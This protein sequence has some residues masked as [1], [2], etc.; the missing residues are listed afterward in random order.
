MHTSLQLTSG[1]SAL[2][3]P[4]VS[5]TNRGKKRTGGLEKEKKN[6]TIQAK[7]HDFWENAFSFRSQRMQGDCSW[8][9]CQ[10]QKQ[11]G[12]LSI[13][14]ACIGTMA[15]QIFTC[16]ININIIYS[17]SI[18][19]FFF[20]LHQPVLFGIIFL[21]KGERP[22]QEQRE[23]K[24]RPDSFSLINKS[25]VTTCER[26]KRLCILWFEEVLCKVWIWVDACVKV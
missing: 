16:D 8:S 22:A 19:R 25:L 2:S 9:Q 18:Y 10:N 26:T 3:T 17:F 24:R 23:K 21:Y 13:I 7:C 15:G 20:L 5:S 14:S 6:E 12:A 1:P 11:N 4:L